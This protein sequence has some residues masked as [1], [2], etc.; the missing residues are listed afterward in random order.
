MSSSPKGRPVAAA[1]S[2]SAAA[3]GWFPLNRVRAGCVVI[4]KQLTAAPEVN[5]RLREMG[6]GEE[7]RV[8][9]ITLQN[10]VL[11]Q[12]C[13]ARLGLSAALA[14]SILVEPTERVRLAA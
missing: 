11:C 8:K 7:Q 9:V 5:Q 12:V 13:N 14:A 6:F 4:V 10:N 1:V 2:V 3:P